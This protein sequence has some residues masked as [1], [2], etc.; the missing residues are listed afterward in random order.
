MSIRQLR[1]RLAR[2]E[3]G[4]GIVEVLV[5]LMIFA[6]IAIGM[7][8][9]DAQ[10]DPAHRRRHRPRDGHEPR[11]RRDRPHRGA[12]RRVQRR[13][14][15]SRPRRSS[16]TASRYNVETN[17]GWVGAN[18]ST[19][20]CGIGG[21]TLQY[22]RV[23]VTVTWDGHVPPEP[24]ARRL[25]AR[26]ERP[27]QRPDSAAPSSSP[28]SRRTATARPASPSPDAETGGGGQRHRPDRPDRLRRLHLRAE[29]ASRHLQ[30][31][32]S[33][34]RLHRHRRRRCCRSPSRSSST[35]GA[36]TPVSVAGRPAHTFTDKYAA[37]S[38]RTASCPTN[39]DITYFG[40]PRPARQRASPTGTRKLYP[41]TSGYQARRGQ[42]DDLRCV[43]PE[44][45]TE[46]STKYAGVRAA[47][48]AGQPGRHRR[49]CPSRW[50]SS[51]S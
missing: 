39:L 33:T 45:W 21:G 5:A 44:K 9:L 4:M 19:G 1:A 28:S 42:P 13:T 12:S 51:T 35:R 31:R 32:R 25:R 27:H 34:S 23:R 20:K 24:G 36:T 22:K 3:S 26:A 43:D 49:T 50:A 48:V 30:R 41:W 29:G 10:H 38:T 14:T 8:V 46:T 6:I 18:G 16:S 17:T 37:N 2:D 7:V 11:R 47:A 40:R 15:R